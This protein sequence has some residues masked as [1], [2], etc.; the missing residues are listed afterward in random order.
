MSELPMIVL[1]FANEQEGRRYLRDL[2]E[3]L[4]RLQE[5]LKGAERNVLCRPE[6]LPNATP[7]QIFWNGTSVKS[8][9]RVSNL[10]PYAELRRAE[11]RRAV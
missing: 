3:K 8:R 7:E 9:K 10:S 2:P 11:H 5:I 6:R 4:R 1:A